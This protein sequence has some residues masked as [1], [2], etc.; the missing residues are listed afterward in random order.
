MKKKTAYVAPQIADNLCIIVE[1]YTEEHYIKLLNEYFGTKYFPYNCKGGNANGVLKKTQEYISEKQ[2]EYSRFIVVYDGDTCHEG[3]VK[4]RENDLEQKEVELAKLNP[5][6]ENCVL[7]HF[8]K[9]SESDNCNTVIAKLKAF[10]PNYDKNNFQQ[11]QKYI[12]KEMI[13]KMAKKYNCTLVK[14]NFIPHT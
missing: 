4:Q 2:G 13:E 14:T 11:L 3:D 10:I 6:F 9:T 7:K 1:G 12:K 8:G 5:C